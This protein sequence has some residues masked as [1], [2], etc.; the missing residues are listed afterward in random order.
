MGRFSGGGP[1]PLAGMGS[2]AALL[3]FSFYLFNFLCTATTPLVATERAAGR[4]RKAEAVGGQALSLS[5][6]LGAALTAA[7]FLFRQ[8]LLRLMGTGVT[9]AAANGYALDFLSVRAF[10]APAVLC[11]E[12]STGVLRGYLDTRTPIVILIAANLLNLLLDVVLIVF[13]GL[14]PMGAAIATTTSEWISAGLFLLVLAGKLP[15]AAGELGS[16]HEVSPGKRA[17]IVP[18]MSIPEFSEVKP[19]LVASSSV[20]FR[21]LVLQVS[22]SAA[23]ATAARGGGA[24]ATGAAASIAAHQIGIQVRFAACCCTVMRVKLLFQEKLTSSL[25]PRPTALATV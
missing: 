15:S 20:F 2:A 11:I 16:N 4:E 12:A 25:I 8:P 19:L 5:L 14:G 3:T 7:L 13:A 23:A 21:A 6:G 22:L 10:A 9:G 24:M 1:Y 17:S 18:L